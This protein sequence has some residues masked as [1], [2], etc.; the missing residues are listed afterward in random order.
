M[1]TDGNVWDGFAYMDCVRA[2]PRAYSS[3]SSPGNRKSGNKALTRRDST[4][5]GSRMVYRLL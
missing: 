3:E 2:A 1:R 4:E 5:C